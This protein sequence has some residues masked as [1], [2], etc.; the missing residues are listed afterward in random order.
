MFIT[1]KQVDRKAMK[2][3][4]MGGN[5]DALVPYIKEQIATKIVCY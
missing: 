2:P 1:M 4:R 5:T 3:V